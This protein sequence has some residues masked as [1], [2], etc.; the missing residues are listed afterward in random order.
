[1]HPSDPTSGPES[2]PPRRRAADWDRRLSSRLGAGADWDRRL[3]S[4]LAAG[5]DWDRRLSSRLGADAD[6]DR[7]LSS[8]LGADAARCRVGVAWAGTTPP[9]QSPARRR[10]MDARPAPAPQIARRGHRAPG[11]RSR[12]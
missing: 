4:R 9:A 3:S 11:T 10:D 1:V 7:R 2:Q 8:R 12:L 5:A 6:W